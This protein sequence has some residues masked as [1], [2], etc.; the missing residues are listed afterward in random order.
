MTELWSGNRGAPVAKYFGTHQ[1][2]GGEKSFNSG[3]RSWLVKGLRQSRKSRV[4]QAVLESVFPIRRHLLGRPSESDLSL[5]SS[6]L[7]LLLI[8]VAN[9]SEREVARKGRSYIVL[10]C[11]SPVASSPASI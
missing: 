8:K 2:R 4:Q 9:F 3:A 10:V 5:V 11:I 6:G 1:Y 7:R